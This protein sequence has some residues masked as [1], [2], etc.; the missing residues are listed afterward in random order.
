MTATA[1]PYA[2]GKQLF[3]TSGGGNEDTWNALSDADKAF[4]QQTAIDTGGP[5]VRR[6][7]PI[8]G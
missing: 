6:H 2:E 8:G 1:D 5:D 7:S 4:W 3:L